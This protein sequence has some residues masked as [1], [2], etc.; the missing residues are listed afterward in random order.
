MTVLLVEDNEAI[1]LGLEYLFKEEKINLKTAKS[2]KEAKEIIEEDLNE[3]NKIDLILLDITL[4]DGNGFDLCRYIKKQ[5]N[6][7]VIFLTSKDE[8]KD[9]VEG[10]EIGAE[11]YIIKP[12]RNR[13]LISRIKNVLRRKEKNNNEIACKNIK[14]DIVSG[15]VYNQNEEVILTKLE[16]KILLNL[17][18]NMNKL[19][20]RE[21]IL[22][23]IWDIAGNFVN[24]NTLTVYIKR[25]REKIGD[26]NGEIIE[27]VRGLGYRVG[28]K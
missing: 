4:P 16:Y 20:T 18:N 9:V 25:I 17:F 15:K 28:N 12:F 11:D 26:K 2:K 10:L 7:P 22:N 5:T 21:E 24:D 3:Q 19:I 8:E 1:I 27:T 23:D 14:I 6:Y 13:E